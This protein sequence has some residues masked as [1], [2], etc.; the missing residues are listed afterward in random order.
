MTRLTTRP[1]LSSGNATT[2]ES[3]Y[4]KTRLSDGQQLA[5]GSDP[6]GNFSY[7]KITRGND[8]EDYHKL[9]RT[10]HLIAPTPFYQAETSA[11]LIDSPYYRESSPSNWAYTYSN[12]RLH[13]ALLI[14]DPDWS[15]DWYLVSEAEVL[16]K[17]D[18]DRATWLVTAAASRIYSQS[19]DA[20]TFLAEFNKTVDLFRGLLSRFDRILRR[21]RLDQAWLEGRYGWR[22]LLYDIEDITKLLTEQ[23]NSFTRHKERKDDRTT[24]EEYDT[25]TTTDTHGTTAVEYRT[26]YDIS[27]RGS[28][29]ADVTVPIAQFNPAVTIWEVIPFSFVLDWFVNV[30]SFIESMSLLAVSNNI[31]GSRGVLAKA[32]REPVST[33]FTPA[34]AGLTQS[35]SF[36]G[37]SE[38]TITQRAQST[39][40]QSPQI[41]LNID[42]FK[43]MDLVSLVIG[44]YLGSI[45][46]IRR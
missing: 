29:V 26:T 45:G 27:Y 39:V 43:V 14:N 25:M 16:T 20:L 34:G 35:G 4:V 6:F 11:T 8:T 17:I 24:F 22:I 32:Q 38:V 42:E 28:I 33:V 31:V 2:F 36:L 41:R 9:L 5:S 10:G 21:G 3:S 40:P 37:N 23:R 46:S 1:E 19:W 12:A 30:G 15:N 13:Y 18:L 44:R 7:S